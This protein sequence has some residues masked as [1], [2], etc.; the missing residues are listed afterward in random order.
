MP[1]GLSKPLLLTMAI[2]SG[3]AVANIYYNQPLLADIAGTFGITEY[4]A[5]Y[6]STFT[7]TGYAMG[8]LLFV[9]LGDVQNRRN[10]I[11]VL[12][13]CVTL[14]LIG[15][16]ISPTI[17]WLYLASLMVGLTTV[18]PQI[19]IPFSAQLAKSEQRGKV[20]GTVTSG[21]LFGILLAR[22]VSGLIGGSIGWRWMYVIAAILMFTLLTVLRI[23]L[24][25]DKQQHSPPYSQLLKSL[26]TLL[27]KHRLLREAI[28]IGALN[29]AAFSL[30]W[31][32]LVF[33]LEGYPYHYSSQIAGLFGLVGVVGALG[34]PW[35]GR[36]V[37]RFMPSQVIGI[38]ILILLLSFALF[39]WNGSVLILILGIILMDLGVQGAQVMNQTRI[40]SLDEG[41]KSRLNTVLMVSTFLGGACGSTLSSYLWSIGQWTYVSVAGCCL[42]LASFIVWG[43]SY[44][45]NKK[46]DY[47]VR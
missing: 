14:A 31:T 27:R 19:L 13:L 9:P 40:Y 30:F 33:L 22:T 16:A 36:L 39:V 5:G 8:L 35:I 4:Q 18:V 7:Q 32:S 37:D 23:E 46:L 34:V 3:L 28:S 38:M 20:I 43:I 15:M 42:V 10:L 2:A 45:K 6:V 41:A 47:N 24:P 11:T 21:L 12:L 1:N 26:W 29:F 17:I 25:D 44:L